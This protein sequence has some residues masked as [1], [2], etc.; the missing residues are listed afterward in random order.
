MSVTIAVPDTGAA[1]VGKLIALYERAVGFYASLVKVNAY[2]QPGVE[3][4][5]QAAAAVLDLQKKA[6]E[7]LKT[8]K[9]RGFGAEDV[10][11]EIGE[12]AETETIF[13]ILEHASANPDHGIK[14]AVP[15]GA[16]V[17][18]AKYSAG[19]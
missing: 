17:F 4:G 3:A 16:A 13:K 9:G 1:T 8:H 12:P 7:F 15:K 19:R 11:R 2:H 10:A 18:D 14:R 6:L 5:K